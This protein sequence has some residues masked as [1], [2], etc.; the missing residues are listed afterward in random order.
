MKHFRGL[1]SPIQLDWKGLVA[2]I[3]RQ[4]T[5][6]RIYHMELFHDGE[7]ADALV[8]RFDLD[9]GLDPNDPHYGKRRLLA[10]HRFLGFDYVCEYPYGQAWPL[11]DAKT[12]DS[13]K[14]LS[15][16]QRTYRDEHV[17]PITNWEQFETYPWPDA[18]SAEAMRN[19]EWWNANLP[20]DMCLAA[21]GLGHFCELL[22][23]LMGYETLCYALS[24]QRDLVE[25]IAARLIEYYRVLT[26]RVLQYER[27]RIL[28][29]SDDMGFKTGL[30]ISPNDMR[31][32]VLPGHREQA[33][34]AH[35]A[36]RPYLLHACGKLT[37]IM[38]DLVHDVKIDAKHS[39]EDTIEDIRQAKKTYG[40][41]VALI[42]GIDMDFLCRSDE[43]AIRRRVR[44]TLDVCQP[45][46]G[47]CLGTG[48]SVANY[49]PVDHYLAMV[50]EGRL[51]KG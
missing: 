35:A 5:P 18:R 46:G 32:F 30:L 26:E 6:D 15:R 49:I 48:N 37:D 25:A 50:D 17:G 28:F 2:N 42:G 36:G 45:G 7:M 23:W 40:K 9:R 22:S 34:L 38:D 27:I 21:I 31:E 13:A 3:R 4:G 14:K 29:S 16:G 1:E 33:A 51:Y 43:A 24:D 47:Y 11:H 8:K 12:E 10:L 41:E 19:Y 20:D 39:F 44:E